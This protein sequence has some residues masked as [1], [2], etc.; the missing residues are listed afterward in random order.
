MFALVGLLGYAF[1]EASAKAKIVNVATNL[2]ALAVF[3]PGGHV[4]WRLAAVMAVANMA[5]GYAGAH[6]A[7][8][9]GSRFVRGVFLSVVA[10]FIIRLGWGLL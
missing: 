4:L 6:T 1:L 2:G 8:A 9:L 10:G 3:A 7:V 5:G